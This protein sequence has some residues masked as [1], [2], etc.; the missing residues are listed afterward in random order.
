MV[1]RQKARER[2]KLSIKGG[3][4]KGFNMND[5]EDED[6]KFGDSGDG[7]DKPSELTLQEQYDATLLHGYYKTPNADWD[8]RVSLN[9]LQSKWDLVE[10]PSSPKER[11][12][13]HK[14]GWLMTSTDGWLK[15]DDKY[16][17]QVL[18]VRDHED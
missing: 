2:K 8:S 17:L 18:R 12:G 13:Q 3:K 4:R 1:E 16:P 14:H 5:V 7:S 9:K 10:H 15:Q 11:R 6:E